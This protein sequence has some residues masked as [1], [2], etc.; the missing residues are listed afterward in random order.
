MR[1]WRP[2]LIVMMATSAMGVVQQ[3]GFAQGGPPPAAVR[4]GKVVEETL[5]ERR[6]VT[7]DIVPVKRSL[8]AAREPGIVS[9]VAVD[10]GRA[11]KQG[12]LLV[13]LDDTKLKIQLLEMEHEQQGASAAVEQHKALVEQA[14]R[15]EQL[16]RQA[17]ERDAANPKELL[18]RQ[19][20]LLAAR[21]RL[22]EAQQRVRVTTTW[23]D[24]FR[25]RINDMRITAP[26]DGV[27]VAKHT[28]QGQW[29]SEGDSIIE[30]I[31]DGAVEAW[32]NVPQRYITAVRSVGDRASVTIDAEGMMSEAKYDRLIPQ[33]DKRARTFT[34]VVRL[35]NEN[36]LM[37]SGMSVTGWVP[38][39]EQGKFLTIPKDA[40]LRSDVGA[41]VYV[42]RA[43][44]GDGPPVVQAEQVRI[45][46]P[47][48]D[49]YVIDKSGLR[50]GDELVT[51]GNERLFPNAP[52][53]PVRDAATDNAK[54]EKT[55]IENA[56]SKQ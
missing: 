49:R 38:T 25:T 7:G 24:M 31:S 27:V 36:M 41:F 8:V 53:T 23:A 17:Y 11:I 55:R 37:A 9:E 33:M 45:L 47:S 35:E 10:E 34:L 43:G 13:R 48:G 50:A 32:L 15:D 28:E 44:T 21:A 26:F 54:S 5:V 22:T 46:Y 39:G 3:I 20:S 6:M 14:E 42:V 16:L 4:V 12:D 52:V 19:S 40:I 29:V 18:D 2:V 1:H 56:G 30:I 51:E